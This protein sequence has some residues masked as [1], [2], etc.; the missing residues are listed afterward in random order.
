M[1]Y[2]DKIRCFSEV[3]IN[4]EKF[5]KRT[6]VIGIRIGKP[7]LYFR[8]IFSYDKDVENTENMAGLAGVA[9][10]LNYALFID[11]ITLNFPVSES[12]R[13]FIREMARIN[14]TEV[15][16]NRLCRR[17]YDF[18]RDD[19][20]PKEEEINQS[21]AAGSTEFSF[22]FSYDDPYYEKGERVA[23]LSSGGKESLMTTGLMEEIGEKPLALFFNESGGH[24]K[25]ALP[26]HRYFT[27]NGI[28]SLKV[29]SNVDRF[30][31]FMNRNMKILKERA[32]QWADD[33][34]VQLFTFPVYLISFIPAL[35]KY[36]IGNILMGN[37][38]DDPLE[39]PPFK[40]IRH[41][42]GVYDQTPE[43]QRRFSGYLTHKGIQATLWSAVYPI[44]GSVVEDILVNRYPD[45]YSLQRSCHSCHY[46]HNSKVVP[47]GKCSKCL[48]VRLFIEYARGDP[49]TI[50]Y[51]D[52]GNLLDLVERER[53]KLD[54]EELS[55]MIEGIKTGNFNKKTHVS[56][57][58]IL[59]EEKRVFSQIPEKFREP[60][61][62][63]LKKYTSGCWKLKN[64][65]W[66]QT[67]CE[68]S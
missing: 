62:N 28:E 33:Y 25:L 27:E 30:Y 7:D 60:V 21:N 45:L 10:V 3:S 2:S 31:N 47:C 11:R 1:G 59:P 49:R 39:E 68:P 57:I 19:V 58:H 42:Y 36:G 29:W 43:F 32:F 12:D 9:A 40:G 8:I 46:D 44:Y 50:F 37:E 13:E 15:F 63:I 38:F 65:G 67:D 20:I 23:V 17:R 52:A 54:P 6:S 14:N 26:S 55:C 61:G 22:N 16:V 5:T 66:V 18:F 51:P 56:G 34:P 64:N 4:V 24:W 53:L 35:V 41:Y 48:G